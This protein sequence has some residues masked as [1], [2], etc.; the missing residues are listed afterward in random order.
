MHSVDGDDDDNDNDN[1]NDVK[2]KY[3]N[4]DVVHHSCDRQIIYKE[5]IIKAWL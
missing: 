4:D 5:S 3:Q 1:A 2:N